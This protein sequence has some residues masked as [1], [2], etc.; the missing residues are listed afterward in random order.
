MA[1]LDSDD[2]TAIDNLIATRLALYEV[3][4]RG[5]IEA[6]EAVILSA[7]EG[8]D[9]CPDPCPEVIIE[10]LVG[11]VQDKS[12][13]LSLTA[14]VDETREFTV[15]VFD[16]DGNEVDLTGEDLIAVFENNNKINLGEPITPT[17]DGNEVTFT[18]DEVINYRAYQGYWSLRYTGTNEVIL[19]GK[20]NVVYA[21]TP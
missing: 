17:I 20:Y 14:F 11:T 9:P 4:T 18:T 7:I 21:A 3:P 8:I 15:S 1:T 12:C 16:S 13:G 6:A 2:L 10:P 19:H 5:D